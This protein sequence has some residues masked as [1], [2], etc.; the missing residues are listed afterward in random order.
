M[1]NLREWAH[2]SQQDCMAGSIVTENL[3]LLIMW[4]RHGTAN[5]IYNH[6]GIIHER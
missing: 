1:G 6:Q 3:T 4:N 5:P 2:N